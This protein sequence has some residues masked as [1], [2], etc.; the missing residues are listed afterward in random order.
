MT[1]TH[2][3][4]T[5]RYRLGMERPTSHLFQVEL[6]LDAHPGDHLDLAMPAWTP[7]AYKLVDNARNVRG[8]SAIGADGTSLRIERPDFH[9]WRVHH[10]GQA[11]SFRYQVFAN[12]MQIHQ[13]QLD[14][15]HAFVNGC[16]VFVHPIGGQDWPCELTLSAPDGWKVGTALERTGAFSFRAGTYD[17][18]IDCPL[19]IGQ[20]EETSFVQDGVHYHVVWNGPDP[21]DVPKLTDG[22]KKVIKAETDFWGPAPF[23]RYVFIY[24]VTTDGFLNGLEHR[25][26]TAIQGN[27]NLERNSKGFFALT[28][29]EFFHV[30]NVKRLRRIWFG[31]FDYR[32]PSHPTAL[33]LVECFTV[34]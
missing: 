8:V 7:G 30:W 28:A 3:T 23:D 5:L 29:H 18:F 13:A 17:E 2:A 12:K 31:P 1:S 21:M 34:Y 16:A 22:L 11:F 19:E 25:N 14:A 24:N 6:D 10:E 26:S 27:I 20:F 32:R 33:W 15:S 4:P 9:T